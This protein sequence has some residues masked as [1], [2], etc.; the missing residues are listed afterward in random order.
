MVDARNHQVD[1]L[2]ASN[3]R[4]DLD[5]SNLGR[6]TEVLTKVKKRLDVTQKMIEE[7]LFYAEGISEDNAPKRD[8]LK[9]ISM[10]FAD[11][12]NEANAAPKKLTVRHSA[13][14]VIDR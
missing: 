2:V 6:A 9:E 3:R 1:A 12:A 10:Q 4:F 11:D 14:L 8:I 7:D 13:P 5:D